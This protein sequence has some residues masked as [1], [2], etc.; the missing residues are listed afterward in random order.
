MV[1]SFNSRF[2]SNNWVISGAKLQVTEAG[3]PNNSIFDQGKGAFEIHWIA[4][5]DWTE[6]TGTPNT[7]TTDGIAYTNEPALLTDSASLGTFTNTGTSATLQFTL[8]L[9]AAFVADAQAGGEVGLYLTAVDPRVGFTFNSRSFGAVSAR[10]S[11]EISALP[12][13]GISAINLSGLVV[14]VSATNGAAGATYYTL[15]ITN[16][17]LPLSQWHPVATNTL[18]ADGDFTITVTN[19]ADPNA[20]W[21]QFFVLQAQ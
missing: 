13:P 2:S 10:P 7:P 3:T 14:V 20:P 21:Q 16:A 9:P 15:T 18:N 5:D 1:T 6:G 17:L 4:D 8:G 19:A 12:E 11:L